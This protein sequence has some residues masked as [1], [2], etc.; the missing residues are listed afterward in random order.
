MSAPGWIFVPWAVFVV[1]LVLLACALARHAASCQV[2]G[3]APPGHP[4][5]DVTLSG[6]EL[7]RLDEMETEILAGAGLAILDGEEGT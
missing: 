3:I 6:S 4:D 1:G 7:D 2:T 5:L